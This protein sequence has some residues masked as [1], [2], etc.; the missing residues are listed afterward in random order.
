MADMLEGLAP[1]FLHMSY[2]VR[3]L[4]AVRESFQRM[5]GVQ[6]FG[7]ME[8]PMA[9]PLM[10]RGKPVTTPFHIKLAVGRIG[11]SGE[12][13]IELIQPVPVGDD[14]YSEFL[15]TVGSGVHHIAFL[16]PDWEKATREL[17][18]NA[19]PRILE[20]QNGEMHF[21]YFDL[22][23]AVGSV[24]EI[25]QYDRQTYEMIENLKGPRG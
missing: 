17:R 12:S 16:V 21:A 13:E 6:H 3:D 23:N 24:V 25:V 19:V 5:L 4:S 14:I 7:M 10:M 2:V 11:P 1:Y 15:T 22:R 8:L 20:S 18:A 9:A